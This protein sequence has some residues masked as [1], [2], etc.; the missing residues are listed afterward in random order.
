LKVLHFIIGHISEN[1]IKRIA[2]N[3][4]VDGLKFSYE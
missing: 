4:L 3:N 1:T 2:K